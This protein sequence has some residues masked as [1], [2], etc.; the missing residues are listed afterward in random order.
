MTGWIEVCENSGDMTCST[1]Q[2]QQGLDYTITNTSES[3]TRLLYYNDSPV[4]HLF[5]IDFLGQCVNEYCIAQTLEG[6]IR[7]AVTGCLML[8]LVFII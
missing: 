8:V 5:Q 4:E 7:T 3:K 1:N 2:L 6:A